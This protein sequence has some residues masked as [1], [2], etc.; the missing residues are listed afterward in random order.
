M[1][2]INSPNNPTGNILNEN[3]ILQ[4]QNIVSGTKILIMSDEVYEHIYFRWATT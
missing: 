4:L 3:D 1:I 2:I